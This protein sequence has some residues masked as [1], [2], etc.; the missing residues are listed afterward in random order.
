MVNGRI[1]RPGDV[2]LFLFEGRKG[3]EIVAEV[4][5]R[6]LNSPLDSKLTILGARNEPLAHNDDVMEKDGHLHLGQGLLT[7]H[8]DSYLRVTLPEDGFYSVVLGDSQGHGSS[9]YAY[10]L[11]LSAPRPRFLSA[12]SM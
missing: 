5:A 8:A 9:A 12:S 1:G 11:R 6:R 7:H 2:D 10:R 4:Q 3:Q